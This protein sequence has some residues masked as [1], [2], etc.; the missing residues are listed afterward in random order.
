M[1]EKT[2][3]PNLIG[4]IIMLG[5]GPL[6][7]LWFL[8]SAIASH[9]ATPFVVLFCL[10]TTLGSWGLL[11]YLIQQSQK[12]VVELT[13]EEKAKK[14]ET[15]QKA[16]GRAAAIALPICFG[17]LYLLGRRFSAGLYFVFGILWLFVAPSLLPGATSKKMSKAIENVVAFS[18]QSAFWLIVAGLAIWVIW[19]FLGAIAG[20]ST[21][22]LLLFIIIWQLSTLQDRKD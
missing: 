20:M 1:D 11:Y 15:Q 14:M 22:T 17:L 7:Y 16:D 5:F 8:G 6:L 19:A 10:G 3:K 13:P 2:T 18:I 9:E 21:T 12:P 4:A